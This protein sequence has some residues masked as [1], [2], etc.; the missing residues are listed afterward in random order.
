MFSNWKNELD[1]KLSKLVNEVGD[2]KKEYQSIK[3]TNSEMEK[4]ME[5][6]N[7]KHEETVCKVLDL[8]KEKNNNN[9]S[10]K[11]LESQI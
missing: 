1:M 9:E 4:G 2:L 8:E 7:I 10:I 3:K 6:I 5:F 11:L